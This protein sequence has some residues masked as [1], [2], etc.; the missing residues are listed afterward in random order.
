MLLGNREMLTERLH[1][2]GL[3]AT[4]QISRPHESL[5]LTYTLT[6]ANGEEVVRYCIR[7]PAMAAGLMRRR[8][9]V[10]DLRLVPLPA[11]EQPK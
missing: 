2:C 9:T 5:R 7:T 6:N 10:K 11:G 3:R 1:G 8:L 4:I